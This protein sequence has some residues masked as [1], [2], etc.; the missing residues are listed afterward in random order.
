MTVSAARGHTGRAA[1]RRNSLIDAVDAT[2]CRSALRVCAATASAV[3]KRV[4]ATSARTRV[5][6]LGRALAPLVARCS[7]AFANLHLHA[8][9]T[10]NSSSSPRPTPGCPLLLLL[11]PLLPCYLARITAVKPQNRCTCIWVSVAFFV[12]LALHIVL[13]VTL[14]IVL[15]YVG[16]DLGWGTNAGRGAGNVPAPP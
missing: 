8:S 7:F 3:A 10:P 12:C 4:R 13:A 15:P 6:P 9:S 5:P 14:V 16:V 2:R 11:L 1:T